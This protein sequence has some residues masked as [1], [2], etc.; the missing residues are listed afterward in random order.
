[1]LSRPEGSHPAC[2]PYAS[3]LIQ[4]FARNAVLPYA[5]AARFNSQD[6]RTPRLEGT[7]TEVVDRVASWT[8]G[9]NGIT[10][11]GKTAIAYPMA[12]Q[13]H[14]QGIL[15]ASFSCSRSDTL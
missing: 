12:E 2:P 15:S 1:M 5:V 11:T 6:E 10:G 4:T 14:A 9:E 8:A 7:R 3:A 13:R